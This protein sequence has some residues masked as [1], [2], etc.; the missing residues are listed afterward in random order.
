MDGFLLGGAS[1]SALIILSVAVFGTMMFLKM[2]S[3]RMLLAAALLIAIYAALDSYKS[4]S[5]AVGSDMKV[6]AADVVC[7]DGAAYKANRGS[8]FSSDNLVLLMDGNSTP[9]R[10][11]KVSE[12]N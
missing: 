1:S 9:V 8:L 7:I 11:K 10:C 5:L 12:V 2:S 6:I 3:F 4:N